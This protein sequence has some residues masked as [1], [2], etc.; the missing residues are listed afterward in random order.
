[1]ATQLKENFK[2]S[3]NYLEQKLKDTQTRLVTAE[4]GRKRDQ[5]EIKKS[6]EQL[7]LIKREYQFYKD[8]SEKLEFRQTDELQTLNNSVRK[9]IENEKDYKMKMDIL[10]QENQECQ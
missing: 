7:G 8:L 3:S 4:E 5:Q 2:K 10:Q 1:M 6:N 9:M